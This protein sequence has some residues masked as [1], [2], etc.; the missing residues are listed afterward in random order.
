MWSLL[1]EA[2]HNL[3][4]MGNIINKEGL[5]HLAE[6][7]D[8]K[9]IS[10]APSNDNVYGRKNGRWAATIEVEP[11]KR[12]EFV[13]PITEWST[14][15]T[16]GVDSWLQVGIPRIL[17][18]AEL[19]DISVIVNG[20]TIECPRSDIDFMG[21]Q[22]PM[23]GNP[24]FMNVMGTNN[25]DNGCPVLLM[26]AG[27]DKIFVI[28]DETLICDELEIFGFYDSGGKIPATAVD[29][30]VPYISEGWVDAE[31]ADMGGM[32][33]IT[34]IS[35][36]PD[37][38]IANGVTYNLESFYIDEYPGYNG[39]GN[40][41]L[42]YASLSEEDYEPQEGDV[43]VAIVE[44]MGMYFLFTIGDVDLKVIGKTYVNKIPAEA[45]EGNVGGPKTWEVEIDNDQFYELYDGQS[46][47]INIGD[48]E[49]LQ[50]IYKNIQFGDN[51]VLSFSGGKMGSAICLLQTSNDY[52]W[53]NTSYFVAGD[54]EVCF[55]SFYVRQDSME[56]V[57]KHKKFQEKS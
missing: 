34:N 56:V 6:V 21:I 55:L 18:S 4:I 26:D 29:G 46:V 19:G 11:R 45:I 27:L 37:K 39:V 8:E 35:T 22:S 52:L 54:E 33:A 2:L 48:I 57:Y 31:V 40:Y 49:G 53:G 41:E 30:I 3:L 16:F 50:D 51:F 17:P 43:P 38:V 44:A 42:G 10:D 1:R 7:L 14:G 28:N 32:S 23:W 24:S 36:F 9:Y 13:I 12:T 25:P 20:R 47:S 15:E 5:E